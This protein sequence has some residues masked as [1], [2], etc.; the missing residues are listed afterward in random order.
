[1]YGFANRIITTKRERHIGYATA[2]F[3]ERQVFTNPFR[4]INEIHAIGGVFF[5]T[6]R[7]RKNIR[8]KNNIFRREADLIDQNFIRTLANFGLALIGIGLTFFIKGHDDNGG[9]VTAAQLG[10]LN[11]FRNTLFH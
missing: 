9:T 3:G 2:Y 7:N 10:T 1:M 4:G 11:E 8:V 5:D 6:G